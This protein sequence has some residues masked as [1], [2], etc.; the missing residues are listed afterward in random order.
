MV[1]PRNRIRASLIKTISFVSAIPSSSKW[2]NNF[3]S[4]LTSKYPKWPVAILEIP[5]TRQLDHHI[6]VGIWHNVPKYMF[7]FC[8]HCV[9]KPMKVSKA[10][11]VWWCTMSHQGW[12]NPQAAELKNG[13]INTHKSDIVYVCFAIYGLLTHW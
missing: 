3:Q 1:L 7:C 4:I 5:M 10:M 9:S 8:Y 12:R 2:Q 11:Q 6:N 13:V